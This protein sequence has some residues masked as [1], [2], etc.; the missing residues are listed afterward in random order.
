MSVEMPSG[1]SGEESR[2]SPAATLL[3]LPDTT[4]TCVCP[5]GTQRLVKDLIMIVTKEKGITWLHRPCKQLPAGNDLDVATAQT[6]GDISM[7]DAAEE[8]SMAGGPLAAFLGPNPSQAMLTKAENFTSTFICDGPCDNSDKNFKDH[9]MCKKCLSWQH[10]KCMLYGEAG[11]RGGP[12][13]N[14]CYMDF[15]VHH[16][17]IKKWQ[18]R[19]LMEAVQEATMFLTD[20]ENQHEKWRRA[21]CTK[22]I[23]RFFAKNKA[24][25]VRFV[26]ARREAHQNARELGV[27][28][29]RFFPP[30]RRDAFIAAMERSIKEEDQMKKQKTAL[31]AL[32]S[33]DNIIVRFPRSKV[34]KIKPPRVRQRSPPGRVHKKRTDAKKANKKDTQ[35]NRM[36]QHNDEQE[37]SQS[38]SS[39]SESEVS[40][41]PSP[42][43]APPASDPKT[44]STSND[45][46]KPPSLPSSS[47]SSEPDA[48]NLPAPAPVP[49]PAPA[50]P[51]SG[52]IRKSERLANAS[53]PPKIM[54][55]VPEM[56]PPSSPPRNRQR[57]S[58]TQDKRRLSSP[59]AGIPKKSGLYGIRTPRKTAPSK[60]R[61]RQPIYSEDEE[62]DGVDE[63]SDEDEYHDH[64]DEDEEEEEQFEHD[65]E[66]D[67]ARALQLSMED[68]NHQRGAQSHR[69]EVSTGTDQRELICSCRKRRVKN[70]DT[71]LCGGCDQRQ[72]TACSVPYQRSP[73]RMCNDCFGPANERRRPMPVAQPQASEDQPSAPPAIVDQHPSEAMLKEIPQLCAT[74][75]W[76][77]YAAMP[78]PDEEDG[79]E[80]DDEEFIAPDPGKAPKEW[81]AECEARFIDMLETAGAAQTKAF[82]EPAFAVIPRDN[83]LIVASLRKLALWMVGRGPWRRVREKTGLLGEALGLE[84]KGRHWDGPGY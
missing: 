10:K 38:P 49:A 44:Q 80:R 30:H 54:S 41:P 84:G 33:P 8:R 9:F 64:Q 72:H 25:F 61:K 50:P 43:P 17:E 83:E 12:V 21:W 29:P 19:R 77:E 5:P 2:A 16:E 27:S 31:I 40:S 24:L 75:L 36:P 3:H 46:K 13:C 81:L 56:S 73:R 59:V 66:D 51:A 82:L 67:L 69:G 28:D 58:K 45:N 32:R 11:D 55:E 68:Q 74:I 79:D 57:A 14:H 15:V 37:M 34:H 62:A 78:A 71:F 7:T 52:G 22:F 63:P 26:K 60:G 23:G 4:I 47:S 42:A 6:D 1:A 53:S 35:G 39:H 70:Q 76:K 18:R 48:S 20:P 65:S